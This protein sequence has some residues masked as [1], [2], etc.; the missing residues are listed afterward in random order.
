MISTRLSL[1]VKTFRINLMIICGI[2]QIQIP[3]IYHRV[4]TKWLVSKGIP[5]NNTLNS[6]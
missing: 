4:N 5:W 6:D 1:T 2:Q 3:I